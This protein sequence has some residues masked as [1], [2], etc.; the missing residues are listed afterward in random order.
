MK[1]TITKLPGFTL[2]EMLLVVLMIVIASAIFSPVISDVF[3]T[4]NLDSAVENTKTNLRR[5]QVLA[6][7]GENDSDWGLKIESG[8][9]ILFSGPSFL[10]RNQEFD[11][12]LEFA[13]NITIS[14]DLEIIFIKGEGAPTTDKTLTFSL[15]NKTKT[16]NINSQGL[17]Y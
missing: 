2:I 8:R 16:I 7:I 4:N 11:E 10:N 5:A 17:I 6:R 12:I 9:L 1:I 13:S 3:F 14:G 15:R